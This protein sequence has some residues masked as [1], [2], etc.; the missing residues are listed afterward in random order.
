M[1]RDFQRY[2]NAL[3]HHHG[4][5]HGTIFIPDI[6]VFHRPDYLFR[7]RES[8]KKLT[9]TC[10]TNQSIWNIHDIRFSFY[11]KLSRDE[12]FKLTAPIKLQKIKNY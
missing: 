1:F 5:E 4:G 10:I 3:A 9:I 12:S 11:S 8:A 2:Q 7:T 6:T